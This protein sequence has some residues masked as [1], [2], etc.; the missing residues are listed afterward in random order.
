MSEIKILHHYKLGHGPK[1]LLAFHGIGQTGLTCFQ[2]FSEL[3]GDHYTIYAFDLFFHG[4]SKGVHGNDDF[5]DQDIVTKT[6]W[7]K[8]ISEFLEEN[9]ID[10]FD[11]AAFSMGGRFALAT[12]EEFSKNIDN[13]FLIAPDGVSE[14]PLY[15]LASRFWPT[16]KIFHCVLQNP[17]ILIKSANLF[18]KLGLIHKSLIRFTQFMLADPKRQ[19]TIYRSWLAFRMLKFDIPAVYKKLDGTK[20]YLFIGKYDKLLKAKDVKKLSVLLPEEQYFLLAA[21]H[22]NLVEK[23]EVIIQ[24]LTGVT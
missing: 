24:E 10:R 18:E 6:L 3:L 19:E 11:I 16:R 22:G 23:A 13:A 17:D 21:G 12:L 4:Q 5:S 8:L 2:S 9:Q 20:V 7:K 14:H 1:I 15:T